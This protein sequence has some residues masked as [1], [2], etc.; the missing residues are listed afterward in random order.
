M[1]TYTT[2]AI[3]TS[4]DE[5]SVSVVEG[6]KVISNIRPSQME[7]H[8]KYG[9]VVPSVAK[10]AHEERIDNVVEESLKQAGKDYSDLDFVAV[11]KGPGLAIALEVGIK[12]A[13]EIAKKYNLPLIPINHMEGHLLSG[14][15]QRNSEN[16]SFDLTNL[17][18]IK[19]PNI[20]LLV[21]GGHTEMILIKNWGDYEK[22]GETLDDSCGECLDKSGRIL[23]LGFPAGPI[24]SKFAQ[25]NRENMIFEQKNKNKSVIIKAQNKNSKREYQLPVTMIHSGDLNFSYSGLKTA[26]RQLVEKITQ[27]EYA[28][29]QDR[30]QNEENIRRG[31]KKQEIYDLCSTLEVAAYRP[32]E[33]KFQKAIEKYSPAEIWLGGGV[34]ASARF[35][36]LI[37]KISKKNSLN[38]RVPYS[39]SLTTDNAAMIGLVANIN[40]NFVENFKVLRSENE[41]GELDRVPSL[42]L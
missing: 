36:H 25:E 30:M 28:T 14:F 42:S 26:F 13:K 11:T 12:K 7:F 23:G 8:K 9:G 37:R 1:K 3:D 33:I 16:L 40:L 41:I 2:L 6:L 35:R 15:A 29:E 32:L 17:Q 5:T 18:E 10:L 34:V 38:F 22:I 24:I 31:L 39:S 19:F 20:G 27:S 4:F 21:S